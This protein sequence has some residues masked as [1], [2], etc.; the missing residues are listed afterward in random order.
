MRGQAGVNE[1]N[2][3]PIYYNIRHENCH[4]LGWSADTSYLR[5]GNF[6]LLLVWCFPDETGDIIPFVSIWQSI[7]RVVRWGGGQG[8]PFWWS[9]VRPQCVRQEKTINILYID[10]TTYWALKLKIPSISWS[11]YPLLVTIFAPGDCCGNT[12]HRSRPSVMD[13]GLIT[14]CR[15]PPSC[16]QAPEI[17]RLDSYKYLIILVNFFLNFPRN[18]AS[19][20]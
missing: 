1:M 4:T 11:Q 10:N 18:A 9:H 3:L 6:V 17:H 7:G 16:P 5:R 2:T 20:H 12:L 19:W 15:V 14:S 8:W 13:G